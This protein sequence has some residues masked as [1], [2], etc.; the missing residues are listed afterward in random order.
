MDFAYIL[1]P[2]KTE[3]YFSVIEINSEIMCNISLTKNNQ[4]KKYG[5]EIGAGRPTVIHGITFN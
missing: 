4:H 1:Q 3:P 2:V 5:N